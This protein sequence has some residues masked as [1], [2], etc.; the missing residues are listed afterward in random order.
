MLDWEIE[1]DARDAYKEW[2]NEEFIN[3]IN[4]LINTVKY[5]EEQNNEI[6]FY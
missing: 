5:N 2:Q 3:Y 4:E 6:C 1:A